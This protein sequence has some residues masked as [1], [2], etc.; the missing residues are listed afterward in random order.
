MWCVNTVNIF[1]RMV[2]CIHTS[3][4][5]VQLPICDKDFY[6]NG[7]INQPGCPTITDGIYLFMWIF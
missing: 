1:N 3:L 5:G 6:P 7:G 4:L 2:D